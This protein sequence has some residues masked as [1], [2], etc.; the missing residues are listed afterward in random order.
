[1]ARDLLYQAAA[2][3]DT[4]RE[5]MSDT[6]TADRLEGLAAQLRSQADRETT[7]AL[8]VLDRI[9]TKLRTIETQADEPSVS[10]ALERAREHILSFLDTLD[11]RGM[12]QHGG[13]R[14]AETNEHH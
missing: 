3:V 10:E 1:M 11:D 6:D 5:G 13:S 8:G 7:P 2:E 12:T 4:A 9:H 14:N